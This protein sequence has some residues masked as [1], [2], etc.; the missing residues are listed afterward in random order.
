M[1]NYRLNTTISL[2]HHDILKKYMEKYGTQRSVLEHALENN[3]EEALKYTKEEKIWMKMYQIK[4]L[5]GV[6]PKDLTRNLFNKADLEKIEDYVKEE[7]PVEFFIEW[8]YNKPFKECTLLELIEGIILNIKMQ[9]YAET[10]NFKDEGEY[11]TINIFHDLGVN[12]SKILLIMNEHILDNYG[13][14]FISEFSERNVFFK[15]F[16]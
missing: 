5:L 4:D 2:K 8:I 15:I 3:S 9:C 12:G 6:L 10:V 1:K 16:K 11:F 13:A 14:N 7:I